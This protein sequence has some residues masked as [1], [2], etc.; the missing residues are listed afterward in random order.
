MGA[1]SGDTV[2]SW[3]EYS[4]VNYTQFGAYM[5]RWRWVLL[6]VFPLPVLLPFVIIANG[7]NAINAADA[8][9]GFLG[10]VLL[11]VLVAI[12]SVI[13]VFALAFAITSLW[14]VLRS[15]WPHKNE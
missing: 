8:Q 6:L 4:E 12:V 3:A 2:K 15:Q 10:W 7:Q 5:T 9:L 1:N 13:V 14:R 11:T